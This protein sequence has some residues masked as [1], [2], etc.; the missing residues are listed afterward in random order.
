MIRNYNDFVSALLEAGFSM[1]G[2]GNSDGIY[3]IVPCGWNEEPPRGSPIRW[4][5]GDAETDPWEWR[6]RVLDERGD[7]A[8]AKVF[9]RKSGFITK[10]WYPYFLAARRGGRSFEGACAEGTISHFAK[11]IYNAVAAHE[12][13]PLQAIKSLAGFAR[14][15]K[16]KF[17]KALTDLQMGMF[18]TVCGR[19][20]QLSQ[21]GE[22][23]GWASTV[24][25][26]T[27]RF[28]GKDVFKEAATIG[29]KEARSAISEQVLKLSPSAPPPE[30]KIFKFI[31]G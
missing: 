27:E 13:L 24:F 16:P 25:C 21:Q 12:P 22:E 19:Q 31:H 1:G 6:M 20:Q 3:S 10:E 7:I 28:F 29:A 26:T 8:Y 30:K 15:D 11:R 2:G 4:H 17:D 14:E 9:F 23:Y 18:L 5:T